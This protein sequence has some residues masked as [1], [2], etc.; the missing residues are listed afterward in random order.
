MMVKL[1]E[2][3]IKFLKENFKNADAL[4]QSEKVNDILDP[5]DELIVYQGFDEDYDLNEWGQKA[6]KIYDD[7]FYNNEE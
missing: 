3:E 7:I 1:R 5:L 6:Q 2:H 4:I